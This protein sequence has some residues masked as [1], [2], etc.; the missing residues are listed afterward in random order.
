MITGMT[1]DVFEGVDWKNLPPPEAFAFDAQRAVFA[2]RADEGRMQLQLVALAKLNPARFRHAIGEV[3]ALVHD[4][5]L[6]WRFRKH[7]HWT[8]ER[9][10]AYCFERAREAGHPEACGMSLLVAMAAMGKRNEEARVRQEKRKAAGVKAA[11]T[12][13]ARELARR[14]VG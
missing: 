7:V 5:L 4:P 2:E 1:H 12:R 11:Q 10:I 9:L 14:R 8:W 6:G 3:A 13:A